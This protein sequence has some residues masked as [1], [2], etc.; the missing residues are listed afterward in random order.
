MNLVAGSSVGKEELKAIRSLCV[1]Q[2]GNIVSKTI[3]DDFIDYYQK[4]I[5]K[6]RKMG[7]QLVR[8]E[9]DEKTG[10]PTM[11]ASNKFLEIMQ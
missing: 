1:E 7:M 6:A 3:R 2:F 5:I 8:S 10:E 11:K 9:I 4:E